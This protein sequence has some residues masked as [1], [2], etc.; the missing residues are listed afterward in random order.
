[1]HESSLDETPIAFC[2]AFDML[3]DRIENAMLP[4]QDW[5]ANPDPVSRAY[6]RLAFH[7]DHHV[8][9][10][11][12]AYF[13]PPEWK[14]EAEAEN[15]ISLQSL[16]R[17]A[18]A[19]LRD[20]N[21]LP[22]PDGLRREWLS[23]QI[24]AMI[25]TLRRL[26]REAL[27]VEEELRL[28]YDICPQWTGEREFED[29]LYTLDELLPGTEPLADR[30]EAWDAQFQA[31][32]EK[33]LPLLA[34]CRG[35]ARRRTHQLFTLPEGEEIVLQIYEGQSWS[36]YN[37]YLGS[38]RSRVDINADPPLR[39]NAMLPLIIHE[40][41]PGH[42]TEHALKEQQLYR[43]QRRAEACVQL[44]NAPECV[45]S[46]GVADLAHEVI[47]TDQ[48][49]KAWLQGFYFQVSAPCAANVAHDQAIVRAR[50]QLRSLWGNATLLLHR[51]GVDE[52]TVVDYLQKYGAL[53]EKKARR[54][55]RSI[56]N[57][58]HRLYAFSYQYGYEL[59]RR[60]I[61]AGDRIARFRKLLEQPLTPS[62]IE[63]WIEQPLNV[64]P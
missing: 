24:T 23:K 20:V 45:M 2:Q 36:G 53:T 41:Y 17:D 35:E 4:H 31:P 26:Q 18:E 15:G 5:A 1:M 27:S 50:K 55:Y 21:T 56:S 37:W 12:D 22:D 52:Q 48:E 49:L 54:A 51:D 61:E 32:K 46:E 3:A 9:G 34:T 16:Q 40:G 10:F 42:H 57:P 19:L 8:P 44:I 62:R 38:F 11:I 47:F 39:A 25:A 13:G 58:L 14:A 6:L 43:Q 59:L 30:Q 7:I 64:S 29:A 33:L 63:K 60:Y 28:V